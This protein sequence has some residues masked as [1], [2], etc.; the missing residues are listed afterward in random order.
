MIEPEP[1][2]PDD[3]PMPDRKQVLA[4]TRT[5]LTQLEAETHR[6]RAQLARLE[7]EGEEQ[8]AEALEAQ[9]ADLAAQRSIISAGSDVSAGLANEAPT[10]G[11][12]QPAATPDEAATAVLAADTAATTPQLP[13]D[14][15]SQAT[16]GD[17]HPELAVAEAPKLAVD[18]EQ[19]EERKP[20]FA[21]KLRGLPAWATS[22]GIHVVLFILFSLLTFVTLQEQPHQL[23]A[24]A[25]DGSD[26]YLDEFTEV[27]FTPAEIDPTEFEDMELELEPT[28]VN[29]VSL[30][31]IES[32]LEST[33]AG[34][35][36]LAPGMAAALPTD[37]ASLMMGQSGG[38]A[39][40]TGGAGSQTEGAGKPGSAQFFGAR[41]KGNRFVFVVDNSG[42]MSGGRM[43][44]TLM[45]LQNAVNKMDPKQLFYV[46]FYSDQAYPMFF[47]KSVEEMAPATRENKRMLAAWLPT[48][49]M[50]IGGRLL[51]AIDKAAELD[52]AV[53][54]LL[55]DGDIR[56]RR[57]MSDLTT[58]GGRDFVIHTFGMTVKKPEYA[59]NL[60]AI[61]RANGGGYTPVSINPVAA[62]MARQRPIPY[63]NN[64][65]GPVWGS[66]VTPR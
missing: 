42:S 32:P 23:L 66:E 30:S 33:A 61:A 16:L 2:A 22:L 25:P 52:P 1:S 35:S 41:S 38:I 29:E 20:S 40:A 44:T 3:S 17:V 7:A 31:E 54:Y 65:P 45:E 43:E 62:R 19:E 34:L 9:L 13:E 57:T 58:P 51:D 64:G 15:F 21:A 27:D 14:F 36:D 37:A 59:A 56:S 49:E 24:G 46:I 47:P 39:D 48:V 26:E 53:V 11:G 63:R 4:D 12:H 8:A 50:C 55:S 5:R 18:R 10:I 6:L 28:E 60:A